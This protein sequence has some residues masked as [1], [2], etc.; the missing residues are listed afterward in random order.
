MKKIEKPLTAKEMLDRINT[1]WA[2]K[3][4][5]MDIGYIG[6]TKANSIIK[7]I[8]K[9][10]E[11]DGYKLPAHRI[12]MPNVI[13]YFNIDIKYLKKVAKADNKEELI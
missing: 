6:D 9:A 10:L 3:R 13:E 7:G 2:T 12:P 8:R 1:Q 5:V 4:D 11:V